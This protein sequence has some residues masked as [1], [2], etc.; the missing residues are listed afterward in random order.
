MQ[1][2]NPNVGMAEE[3]G[4][5]VSQPN[6]CSDANPLRAMR[7]TRRVGPGLTRRSM[8]GRAIRRRTHMSKVLLPALTPV[9]CF[10]TR[11]RLCRWEQK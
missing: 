5:M 2:L 8:I 7:W 11:A 1:M 3:V 4:F 6:S 10:E 9:P